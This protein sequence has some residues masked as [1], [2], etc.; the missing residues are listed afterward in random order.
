[1]SLAEYINNVF[2][3][4]LDYN[5]AA[6]L[7][8]T[9]YCSVNNIPPSLHDECSKEGLANAFAHLCENGFVQD[10]D[11]DS[12]KNCV[13]FHKFS[14]K[15]HWIEV[16][17]SLLKGDIEIDESARQILCAKIEDTNKILGFT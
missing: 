14:D 7:C 2:L 17:T 11:L 6:Q 10:P 8:L 3:N 12:A 4:G 9:I 5:S 16:I 13:S 1:M 15:E